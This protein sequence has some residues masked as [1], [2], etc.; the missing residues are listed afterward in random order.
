MPDPAVLRQAALTGMLSTRGYVRVTDAALELGV[1]EVTVRADLTALE[2]SGH[3]VRVH[4]GAMPADALVREAPMESARDR[5]AGAKR[6][7]GVAAARL[8]ASGD[9]VFLDAGSTALAV[10]EALLLRR[11]LQG[12]VVVT[13]A[14]PIALAL[15]AGIPRL[16]VI[17]T[18]G[19]LRPLQHSLVNPFAA[20]M[21]D[22][23]NVDLAVIGCTGIHPERGVTNVN[24]PEAEIKTR[25]I[26]AARR[27]VVVADGS[28]LGRVETA[29][30]APLADVDTL[31]TAGD[32]APGVL[33]ALRD[34]GL[35]V[36][37]VG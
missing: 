18:G 5:A 28:K 36:V 12:V 13:S 23:L 10:A 8:V 19:T 4:G 22:A 32:A 11:E 37:A 21:L 7:I 31:V 26:A 35:D 20:P 25:V 27:T 34:A 14:L 30:V 2:R 9:C 1:S 6:A 15:E 17:V 24:I 29:L 33:D 16:E 3:A